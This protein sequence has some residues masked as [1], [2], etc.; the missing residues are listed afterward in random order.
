MTLLPCRMCCAAVQ[1]ALVLMEGLFGFEHKFDYAVWA[2]SGGGPRHV[3]V[4]FGKPPATPRERYEVVR[5]MFAH[6]NGCPTGD[7]TL[8][9]ARAAVAEVA[10]ADAD[11]YFVFV[12]S[13]ANLGR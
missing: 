9:S 6:A 3:L 10:G 7:H 8:G 12:L 2:H 13:D 1:I 4:D 11:D 5:A